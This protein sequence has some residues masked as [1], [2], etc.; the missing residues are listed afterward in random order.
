MKYQEIEEIVTS[1]EVKRYKVTF[2][3]G[4]T[5]LLRMWL[6]DPIAKTIGVLDKGKRRNGKYLCEGIH[7]ISWWEKVEHCEEGQKPTDKF[8]RF[9]KRAKKASR[10]LAE[11]GMWPD[12]KK[13]IDEFLT[14]GEEKQRELV[15]D[16]LTDSY[17][18]YYR[19][20]REGGKWEK[21]YTT[22]IF[23][24]FALKNCFKSIAYNKWERETYTKM[25][26]QI[27]RDRKDFSRRW[28]NGYDIS[29]DIQM[30]ETNDGNY[31]RGWYAEEYRGCG[32]GH[33]YLLLDA[34]HAIF[35]EDD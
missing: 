6:H 35:Y 28:T 20:A 9:V 19:Q 14:M 34:T 22:Q 18:L 4:S 2:K 31:Y 29:L 23:C 13:E 15:N 27:V 12:I 5:K 33:Y 21:F 17:E 1:Q 26:E 7:H 11:S 16:I 10:Y 32:N 8:A 24:S 30:I 25:V 3:D